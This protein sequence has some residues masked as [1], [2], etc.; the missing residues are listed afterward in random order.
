MP[1]SDLLAS[2][3]AEA[4]AEEA[5]L[6]AETSAEIDRIET[7]AQRDADRLRE[8][9]LRDVE[10][11]ARREADALRARA[12]LAA[13]AIVRQ[14]H[15]EAFRECLAEVRTRLE[16]VRS[17]ATYPAVLRALL[18]ESLAAL[19]GATVLRVDPRDAALA[20]DLLAELDVRLEVAA[21]LQTAGGVELARGDDR[22]VRN[23]VEERLANAEPTLAL[24]SGP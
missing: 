5:Q 19:P 16:A 13:S 3:Q 1:L 14:A 6:E 15:D 22:V 20:V 8:E 7:A 2:L 24:L 11:D 10:D 12:R 18:H 21:T 9:A 17:S 23:T 4:V